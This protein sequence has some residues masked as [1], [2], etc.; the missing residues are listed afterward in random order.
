MKPEAQ[1]EAERGLKM[2]T[3]EVYD[4]SVVRTNWYQ[5]ARKLFERYDY[6]IMPSAQGFPFDAQL[7]WP[8]RINGHAMDTYHRWMEV[9]IPATM[10]GCP[11]LNA[12][13]GFGTAGLPMGIQI[14]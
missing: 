4:A 3:S 12:P 7:H 14:I 5:A 13:A 10:S 11:S 1:W 8:D 2:N 6:F 9:V